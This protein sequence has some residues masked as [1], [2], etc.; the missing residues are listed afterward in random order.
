M[1]KAEETEALS[2]FT[3][4][5]EYLVGEPINIYV[6]ANL[7]EA[8]QT[9]SVTDVVVCDAT[10]AS[11]AE[12]HDLSIALT[13][14]A[15][16]VYVGSIV[17]TSDGAYAVSAEAVVVAATGGAPAMSAQTQGMRWLLILRAIWRFW[18]RHW[19]PNV[20]PEYPLGTIA[21][22]AAF[23]GAAGVLFARKKYK[24]KN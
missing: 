1:V 15:T 21:A 4:K 24:T 12:W 20:V 11:I 9:I 23:F 17:A 3:D 10:N 2:V 7:L 18:C 16:P 22:M 6:K 5:Q 8:G 14:T 13:D 19:K